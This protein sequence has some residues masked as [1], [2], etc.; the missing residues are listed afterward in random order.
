METRTTADLYDL[1]GDAL[2]S[3][4]TQLRQFGGVRA[5]A[6]R[7]VT[8]RCFQ[9]NALIKSIVAERG[10]GRVLV[11]DGGGSLHTA[12]M[13]DLIAGAA[14]ANGWAGVVI[15][16]AVRDAVALGALPIGIKA[17]GT[18][19]RKSAKTG[20]GE[21][22]VPVSFGD[23]VFPPGALVHADDDGVV[24]LLVAGRD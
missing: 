9:D 16:G 5:F 6:G 3:C 1:H 23:C 20:A 17:L 7:A 13:G 12:L 11:V 22:D 18:N 15:N 14:A 4:D 8:V 10:E 24:V 21:R 19:P 2:G